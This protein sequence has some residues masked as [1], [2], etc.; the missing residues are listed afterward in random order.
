MSGS[1]RFLPVIPLGIFKP[2]PATYFEKEKE[3]RKKLQTTTK[4]THTHA[5]A[6]TH[7]HTLQTVF[8]CIFPPPQHNSFLFS[9]FLFLPATSP[10]R[11]PKIRLLVGGHRHAVGRAR[12]WPE[13]VGSATLQT[14]HVHTPASQSAPPWGQ[15]EDRWS[16]R[17]R[18]QHLWPSHLDYLCTFSNEITIPSGQTLDISMWTP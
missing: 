14:L 17:A 1:L 18:G 10:S 12:L 2:K 5:H 7:T 16:Q 4:H 9:F 15:G 8:P 13:R 3:K 11:R 6:H